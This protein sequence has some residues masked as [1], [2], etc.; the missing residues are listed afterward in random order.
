MCE[1]FYEK[2]EHEL[3]VVPVVVIERPE[4]AVPMSDALMEA[5][6]KS[7]E[8]T[9]R[10]S[11][12]AEAI[13]SMLKA[14]PDM[15]VG[16]GT[17]LNVD[18]AKCALDAGAKFIVCPGYSEDVVSYCIENGVDVMPGTVTPSE[19]TMAVNR[20]LSATKFFPAVQYG[21]LST[22]KALCG[23]FVGHRFMPTGGVSAQNLEEYLSAPEV[24][25]CGG[26]W[27]VKPRLFAD[28]DFSEVTRLASET[29][30]I[31]RRLRG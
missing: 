10:T 25:A 28:G 19:V 21:G 29:M 24:I 7:A 20:G 2:L 16:A 9:F 5:G 26:S 22:I 14:H 8:V 18:Q 11:V 13:A 4:D 3:G 12:A 17:V 31:V 1:E 23:P 30:G 27:M 6:M 15:E